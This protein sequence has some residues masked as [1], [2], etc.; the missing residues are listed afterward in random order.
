MKKKLAAALF[1][2]MA[3]SL[4]ACGDKEVVST[5]YDDI[6]QA[7]N[8]DTDTK[9]TDKQETEEETDN[10]KSVNVAHDSVVLGGDFDPDYDGFEYL[11]CETLMTEST[12]NAETGK[13]ESQSINVFIPKGDYASVN[14]DSVYVDELGVYF[15]V[16]LNPYL[17]YKQED[18]LVEENLQYYLNDIYDPFYYTDY[19]G[20]EISNITQLEN[21]VSASVKYCRYDRWDDEYYT[22]FA[23]YYLT[24]ISKDML[25]LVEVEINGDETTGK[26][27]QL[28]AELEAFYGFP[29][30]WDAQE[31]DAWLEAFLESPEAGINMVSTGYLLFELPAGWSED[32]SYGD[33]SMTTF[34]PGGDVSTADCMISFAREYMGLDSFDVG[35][36]LATQEDID[37]YTAYLTEQMGDGARDITVEYLGET[38]LGNAMKISYITQNGSY[39]DLTEVYLITNGYYAYSI[40][41][42]KLPNCDVDVFG[43]AENI[44][45]T[46]KVK[47]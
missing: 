41:A 5:N 1:L 43:I 30:D 3:V 40:E 7:G 42:V 26:T 2:A 19:K 45:S 27:P 33:Y 46:A 34:A 31:A 21:G 17:Q 25:V 23:T 8:R 15:R 9:D 12:E 28:L 44:L 10:D 37:S 39:E 38:V 14:R 35:E 18:Y 24:E 22:V 6:E 36:E 20:V 29:M 11:Y 13:M 32:W 47:E 16:K 4:S